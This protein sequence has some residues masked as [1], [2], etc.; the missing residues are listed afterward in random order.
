MKITLRKPTKSEIIQ[1]H[2]SYFNSAEPDAPLKAYTDLS[3]DDQEHAL[4]VYSAENHLTA[5]YAEEVIG[6][7]GIYP[8]DDFAYLNTFAVILPE[9]RGKKYARL[10][11]AAALDY[12]ANHY[13]GYKFMAALTRKDNLPA[14]QGL[15]SYSFAHEG[16]VTQNIN[17]NDVDYENYVLPLRKT[18]LLDL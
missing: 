14:I 8:D 11:F 18:A 13:G 2:D 7:V 3:A 4:R 1:L 15:K 17:G 10:L 16:T 9:H 12:C 6:F 5:L